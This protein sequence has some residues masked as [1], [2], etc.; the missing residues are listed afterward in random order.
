MDIVRV[1]IDA[2]RKV[3][4]RNETVPL[5]QP[6]LRRT[7]TGSELE[8]VIREV[9]P[10]GVIYLSFYEFNL[11]D[12]A[13]IEAVLDVDETNHMKYGGKFTCSQFAK[14]VWAVFATP[15]WAGYAIALL[16][17]DIHALLFC[18]DANFDLWIIESQTDKRRS[19]LESWQGQRMRMSVVG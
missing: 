10:D 6:I 15:E 16:W 9:F 11:C 18:I 12:I 2:I 8:T 5:P 3:L 1:I 19:N 4:C 7:I 17:T 14:R 13:D